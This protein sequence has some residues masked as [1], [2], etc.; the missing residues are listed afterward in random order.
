[1]HLSSASS[2][3]GNA[4][5]KAKNLTLVP[6]SLLAFC[7]TFSAQ[8]VQ[9]NEQPPS[10]QNPKGP[11]PSVTV[12]ELAKH[13]APALTGQ[14]EEAKKNALAFIDWASASTK[15]QDALV[16]K[17]V[18]GAR[19]NADILRAF[20]DEAFAVQSSDHSRALVTLSLLGEARSPSVK[21]CLMKF[22]NQP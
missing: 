7:A 13:P 8:A 4:M 15:D 16:R 22:V 1:M 6:L 19:E 20:C 5:T 17:T 9:I 2:S 14:G 10:T 12:G 18:A 21:S 3:R 11:R